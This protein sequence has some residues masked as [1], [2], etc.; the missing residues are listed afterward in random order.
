MNRLPR[1]LCSSSETCLNYDAFIS[2][3]KLESETGTNGCKNA[4]LTWELGSM[5]QP[6]GFEIS[7]SKEKVCLL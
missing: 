1:G 7:N 2:G 4:L 5:S 6:K 3:G